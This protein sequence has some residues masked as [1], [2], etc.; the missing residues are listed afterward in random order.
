MTNSPIPGNGSLPSSPSR[1]P[2]LGDFTRPPRVTVR[3]VQGR[4]VKGGF[5][6]EFRGLEQLMSSATVMGTEL[7]KNVQEGMERI[8]AAMEQFA[9]ENAP[10]EDNSGDARSGLRAVPIF[11]RAGAKYTVYLG[12]GVYYGVYLENSNGGEY[13]II[14]PTIRHFQGFLP[15]MATGKYG[16]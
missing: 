16:G 10:W 1:V 5:G 15:M 11:D 6:F 7:D 9:K 14:E 4:F 13:A 12:H 8:A 2:S 3:D